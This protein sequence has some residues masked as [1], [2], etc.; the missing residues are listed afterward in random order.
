VYVDAL[1]HR[2]PFYKEDR[3]FAQDVSDAHEAINQ[4]SYYGALR[5]QL[6]HEAEGA[7]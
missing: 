1:R 6:F 7:M 5:A 2:V 4:L 3:Y